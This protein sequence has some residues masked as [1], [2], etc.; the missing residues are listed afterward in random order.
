MYRAGEQGSSQGGRGCANIA[1]TAFLG[2][3][4][5]ACRLQQS[6]KLLIVSQGMC[7]HNAVGSTGRAEA[8]A[9]AWEEEDELE[10][11]EEGPADEAPAASSPGVS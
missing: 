5:P 8:A 7:M 6:A 10:S 1:W 3:V 9:V 2:S 11:K 4:M